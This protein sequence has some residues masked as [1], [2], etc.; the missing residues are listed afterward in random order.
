MFSARTHEPFVSFILRM[1]PLHTEIDDAL[2]KI[3]DFTVIYRCEKKIEKR[4]TSH[5][6][7]PEST[8]TGLD[9]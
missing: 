2:D 1:N 8:E 6:T 4:K 7:R 9:W 3:G 5:Q